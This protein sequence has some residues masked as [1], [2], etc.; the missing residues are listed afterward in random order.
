M[1][2]FLFGIFVGV[3]WLSYLDF[4]TDDYKMRCSMK[5]ETDFCVVYHR[6]GFKHEFIREVRRD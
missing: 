5:S 4:K 3:I 1:M 2:K 6:D